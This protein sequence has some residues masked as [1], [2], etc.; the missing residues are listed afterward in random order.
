MN[1]KGIFRYINGDV[2]EGEF[3][4]DRKKGKGIFR[5]INGDIYE[6]EY[7]ND[8]C[9]GKGIYKYKDGRYYEG[10]FLED[11]IHGKGMFKYANG[12]IYEGEFVNDTIDS[13]GKKTYADGRV[14]E[15]LFESDEFMKD[16]NMD[17]KYILECIKAIDINKKSVNRL[18]K[19]SD[20]RLLSCSVDTINIYNKDTYELEISIKEHS[21][22]I[23]SCLQL[24]EGRLISCS[25]DKT[26]HIIELINDK[27]YKIISNL[28]SDNIYLMLLKLKKE[29]SS[30]Y[31]KMLFKYGI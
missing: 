15:G 2:Y 31:L 17:Y 29:K 5:Y 20:G 8:K 13:F 11:K 25:K 7:S 10:E 1:G 26:M 27:E 18:L 19:L 30:H 28:K 22:E 23:Y 9:K 21:D 14:E 16:Y 3:I 4:K 12:D 24:S 6:G